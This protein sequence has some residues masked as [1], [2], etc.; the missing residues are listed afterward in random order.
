MKRVIF[1]VFYLLA[2]WEIGAQTYK[3]LLDTWNE[4][5]LVSCYNGCLTDVYYTDGDTIVNG[6]NYKILDGYHYISRS[7]LIRE[8]AE[9]EKVYFTTTVPGYNDEYLLYDFSLNAG[10][11]IDIKNPISPFPFHAGY[12]RIDS[13]IPETL[14]DGNSYRHYYLSPTPSNTVSTTPAEW[15]EGMGSLSMINAPGGFPDYY[16]AG[17]VGCF[18][19]NAELFYSAVDTIHVE[20][21]DPVRLNTKNFSPLEDVAVFTDFSK[22]LVTLSNTENIN[23][24]EIFNIQGK[25]IKSIGNNKEKSVLI[26][27]SSQNAGIYF[28]LVHSVYGKKT[29]RVVIGN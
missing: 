24:V 2:S 3:P 27:F 21:C 25:K 8:E 23:E 18:F 16:G 12:Y 13:I 20:S 28:L 1:C 22:S 11:S 26:D 7:F 15:I 29:F 5:H 10:D 14:V 6:K 9:N 19:K 17:K 4:W